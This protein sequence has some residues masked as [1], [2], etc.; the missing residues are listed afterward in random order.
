MKYRSFPKWAPAALLAAL[1]AVY[2]ASPAWAQGFKW[3]QS[4]R[5]Q[6]EL[7]LTSD[8][9]ARIDEIFQAAVPEL[10]QQKQ[11]LDRLEKELS[12][13]VDST[14]EETAVMDQADRVEAARAELSKARMRM[15]LRMRRL[16]SAEQRLKLTALHEE[17]ARNRKRQDRPR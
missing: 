11:T 1:F 13:M 5:F 3:W 17:W 15:L 7:Q 16:L 9:I 6:R 8:Q 4:E 2:G 12:R 10:R 14:A